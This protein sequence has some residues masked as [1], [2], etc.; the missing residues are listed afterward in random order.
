MNSRYYSPIP[1]SSRV[2]RGKGRGHSSRQDADTEMLPPPVP[3]HNLAAATNNQA[4]ITNTNDQSLVT[5]LQQLT[6]TITCMED[7]LAIIEKQSTTT[8]N[9]SGDQAASSDNLTACRRTYS[10]R[11]DVGG[12]RTTCP[13]ITATATR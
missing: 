13:T 11:M 12:A 7:R 2:S 3:T 1:S 9:Q 5:V 10:R 8:T 4:L 6:G